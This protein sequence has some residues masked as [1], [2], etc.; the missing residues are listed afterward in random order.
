[1]SSLISNEFTVTTGLTG[2]GNAAVPAIEWSCQQAALC[3]YTSSFRRDISLPATFADF[4]QYR[5]NLEALTATSNE[6]TLQDGS[7]LY[8]TTCPS[9]N[10][11]ACEAVLYYL[12]Y[13]YVQLPTCPI[14]TEM[15]VSAIGISGAHA[16]TYLSLFP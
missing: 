5:S 1:M 12:P 15:V 9:S 11:G 13:G 16:C 3:S 14:G 8:S 6:I 10:E 4:S 7:A 2:G